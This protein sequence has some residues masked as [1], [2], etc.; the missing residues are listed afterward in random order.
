MKGILNLVAGSALVLSSAIVF[1]RT[2]E[3]Q[4]AQAGATANAQT[5]ANANEK[6]QAQGSL[7]T[8]TAINAELDKSL[9]SKKAKVGDAVTARTTEAI[10]DDSKVV[11]PKGTKLIGHV[12]RASARGKGDSDS[13]L[14][15]QFDRAEMKGGQEISVQL[16]VL[17]MAAAPGAAPIGGD[18]LQGM[19]SVGAGASAGG[20]GPGGGVA[21]NVGGAASGAASTVPRTTQSAAGTVN[22]TVNSTASAAA[23]ASGA[24][25]ATAQGASQGAVGGVN[26]SGHLATNSRGVFGLNGL[27]LNADTSNSTEGSVIAS[28]GKS[29]QLDSGTRL[30]LVAQANTSASAQR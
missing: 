6:N 10:K 26:S 11:L 5:N 21:S 12:T 20:R 27:S 7:A 23:G 14:A 28:A 2:S 29:V 30:L 24:A 4:E 16:N 8:G 19:G 17:A 25:G 1:A 15:M 22:S 9:D 13:T 3:A 18:D